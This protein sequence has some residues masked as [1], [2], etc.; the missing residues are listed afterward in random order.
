[1]AS[2][3]A[4]PLSGSPDVKPV[5]RP[6]ARVLLLDALDRIYLMHFA[7][8]E[9]GAGVWITPGGGVDPGETFEQAAVRELWEEVGLRDVD[10]GPCVWHRSHVFEFQGRLI[11][12]QERY[13]VVR[14][15]AHDP[16]GHVNHDE[17]ERTQITDQRW[18]TLDQMNAASATLFAPRDLAS[19]LAPILRGAY[20]DVP[21]LVDV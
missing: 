1:M 8:G 19:L 6:A 4:T 12:Q 18:W 20:P 16:G 17:L 21:L 15:D 13:F 9:N 10:L 14:I 2:E 11:D 7:P 3:P 5:P